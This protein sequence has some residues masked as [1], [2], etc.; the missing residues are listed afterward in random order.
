M[1]EG[2]RALCHGRT[3]RWGNMFEIIKDSLGHNERVGIGFGGGGAGGGGRS[4]SGRHHLKAVQTQR[5]LSD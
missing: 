4:L 2:G 1:S 5:A 3:D